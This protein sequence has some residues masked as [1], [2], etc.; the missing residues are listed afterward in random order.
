MSGIESPVKDCIPRIDPRTTRNNEII[1][2][3]NEYL[4]AFL[5]G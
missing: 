1:N 5:K 4:K 2:R 3:E